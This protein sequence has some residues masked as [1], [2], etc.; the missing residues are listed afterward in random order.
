MTRV[1]T[2]DDLVGTGSLGIPRRIGKYWLLSEL[3]SGGMAIVYLG[4]MRGM[5]GFTKLVVLKVLR[6][7]GLDNAQ[8]TQDFMTEARLTARLNHPNI[9]QTFEANDDD[10]YCT[11]VMEYL[12]GRTLQDVMPLAKSLGA[13]G[14]A[15]QLKILQDA[16]QGLHHAHEFVD[17]DGTSLSVV[18]RDI[19]PHNIFATFDGPAKVLDFGIAKFTHSSERTEAGVVKGK[20]RYMAPEQATSE[21]GVDRRTD[22]FAAGVVLWEILTGERMW[23]DKTDIQVLHSLLTGVPPVLPSTLNPAVGPAFDAICVKALAFDKSERFSTCQ[24]MNAAIG[25]AMATLSPDARRGQPSALLAELFAQSRQERRSQSARMLAE[26]QESE[27]WGF[28]NPSV[29]PSGEV[30]EADASTQVARDIVGRAPPRTLL[31]G[32]GLGALALFAL[33]IALWLNG[34]A[35]TSEAVASASSSATSAASVPSQQQEAS[36]EGR[37]V[38]IEVDTRPAAVGLFWD[39]KAIGS[40]P[41]T[42]HERKNTGMHQLRAFARGFQPEERTV[43]TSSDQRLVLTLA[44]EPTRATSRPLHSAKSATPSLAVPAT[45]STGNPPTPR[46]SSA[47]PHTRKP[48]LDTQLP[49]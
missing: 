26:L 33:S 32:A 9:V 14:L 28:R 12:D 11:I 34:R 18:H 24:E 3:G 48:T 15:L 38:T 36:N 6:P 20:V 46:A 44:P 49:W 21:E 25:A 4:V 45:V 23:R 19:S 47:V 40:S 7:Q 16:L 2:V 31:V 17:M 5:G 1:A 39:G 13:P 27:K 37:E 35:G 43:D 42:L 30:V 29:A 8:T 10:G 22:I 41:Q